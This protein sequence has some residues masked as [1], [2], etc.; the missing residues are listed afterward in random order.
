MAP[1]SMSMAAGALKRNDAAFRQTRTG[2]HMASAASPKCSGSRRRA[3]HAPYDGTTKPYAYHI[4]QFEQLSHVW[5]KVYE[6]AIAMGLDIV[7][8]DHEDAPAARLESNF[9][10]DDAVKTAD[11]LSTT[12]RSARRWRARTISSPAS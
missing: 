6:Y 7:Q 2:L 1:I 5:L 4:D 9:M 12:G 3:I 8:G 10:F 11:R